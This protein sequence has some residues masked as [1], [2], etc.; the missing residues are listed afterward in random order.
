MEELLLLKLFKSNKNINL[1]I[2]N[3]V[4][5]PIDK[6]E[7]SKVFDRFY[8]LDKSRNSNTGGHGIGLSIAKAIVVSH[9]GKISADIINEEFVIEV[10]L[11]NR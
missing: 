9:N 7:V 4:I 10:S 5:N 1:V 6:E 11:P 2:S 3:K 8:R